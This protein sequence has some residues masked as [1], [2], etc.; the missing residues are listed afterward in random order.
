[1]A[2]ASDWRA[3]LAGS[4]ASASSASCAN[5]SPFRR[6][7]SSPPHSVTTPTTSAE[8][9]AVAKQLS[10]QQCLAAKSLDI[11][12]NPQYG[13]YDYSGFSVTMVPSVLA[14]DPTPSA[15]PTALRTS[16]TC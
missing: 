14:A 10:K 12:V 4:P 11:H 9:S 13:V 6:A 8:Q 3:S 15:A 16:P 1:M 7:Y 2:S 5:S